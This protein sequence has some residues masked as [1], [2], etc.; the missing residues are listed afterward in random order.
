MA[1]DVGICSVIYLYL[2]CFALIVLV[3]G[4]ECCLF[5]YEYFECFDTGRYLLVL[6]LDLFVY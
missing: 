2:R 5:V 6:C 1:D 4:C 3:F